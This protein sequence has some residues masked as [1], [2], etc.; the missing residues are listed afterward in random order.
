MK[1]PLIIICLFSILFFS[2][3]SDDSRMDMPHKTILLIRHAEQKAQSPDPPLTQEGGQR[4]VRISQMLKAQPVFAVYTSQFLRTKMTAKVI[5][6]PHKLELIEYGTDDL[7]KLVDRL[8]EVPFG[9]MA[10]VVGHSNTTPVVVKLLDD[11]TDY[12]Q[13]NHDDFDQ[14]YLVRI[15]EDGEVRTELTNYDAYEKSL[16]QGQG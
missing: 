10:V 2:C 7:T 15:F 4:A 13:I 5:S 11:K 8:K 1:Y 12:P 6:I 16:T 9:K 3:K 14:I